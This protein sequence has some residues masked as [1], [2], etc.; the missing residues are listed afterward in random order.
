MIGQPIPLIR[1][2]GGEGDG[3][4]DMMAKM[5]DSWKRIRMRD[6]GQGDGDGD[7]SGEEVILHDSMAGIGSMDPPSTGT[8]N[9]TMNRYSPYRTTLSVGL[10]QPKLELRPVSMNFSHVMPEDY[11][12]L[13]D[14]D[15]E[16]VVVGGGGVTGGLPPIPMHGKNTLSEGSIPASHSSVFTTLSSLSSGA[17]SSLYAPESAGPVSSTS[18]S[19][20]PPRTRTITSA[21]DSRSRSASNATSP[22]SSSQQAPIS[23]EEL[24]SLRNQLI[25]LRKTHTLQLSELSSQLRETKDQHSTLKEENKVLL[26]TAAAAQAV[27]AEAQWRPRENGCAACGCTCGMGV[28]ERLM[29]GAPAPA[30]ASPGGGGGRMNGRARSSTV[31]SMSTRSVRSGRSGSTYSTTTNIAIAMD[32]NRS[33]RMRVSEEEVIDFTVPPIPPIPD[34]IACTSTGVSADGRIRGGVM[35]RGRVKTGGARGVFGTGSLYEWE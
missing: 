22:S 10:T 8:S 4:G 20:L 15:A 27:A 5:G 2:D 23:E 7:E 35:D 29:G 26:E 14:V 32:A 33:G 25:N 13:D 18:T 30:S 11:L 19:G 31:K 6:R 16:D 34:T 3:N 24:V 28:S 12:V 9:T 1:K 21:T 17:T